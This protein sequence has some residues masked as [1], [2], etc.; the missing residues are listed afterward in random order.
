MKPIHKVILPLITTAGSLNSSTS[1]TAYCSQNHI[2]KVPTY[3]ETRWV[4]IVKMICV[5]VETK[6]YVQQYMDAEKMQPIPE[7]LW[8]IIQGI[9]PAL[10]VY[11][12]I[13]ITYE[14]DEFG[15]LSYFVRDVRILSEEISPLKYYDWGQEAISCFHK[16]YEKIQ[17]KYKYLFEVLCPMAILL[18]PSLDYASLYP[19]ETIQ[20]TIQNIEELMQKYVPKKQSSQTTNTTTLS[21]KEQF[22]KKG[23]KN[24]SVYGFL[25]TANIAEEDLYNFWSTKLDDKTTRPL[26]CVAFDLLTIL[27]TSCSTERAFSKCRA[28][29]TYQRNKLKPTT[30][31]AQAI[32]QSNKHIANQV[33]Y[34]DIIK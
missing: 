33:K 24:F 34:E 32:I 2:K 12:K 6:G 8:M 27:C 4:S 25:Q 16:K 31:N 18:N 7:S 28:F 15:S 21:K 3:V 1:Y 10:E 14:S 23:E 17:E 22:R 30:A 19:I 13:I 5:L 29:I 26:A 20:A 11:Q 9:K